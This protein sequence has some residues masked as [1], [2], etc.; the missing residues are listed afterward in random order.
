MLQMH[1]MHEAALENSL[2]LHIL[3]ETKGFEDLNK[4]KAYTLFERGFA[5]MRLQLALIG[6]A[7]FSLHLVVLS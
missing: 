7:G 6:F 5:A 4:I 2:A 1:V 3:M